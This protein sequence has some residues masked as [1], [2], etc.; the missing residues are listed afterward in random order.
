MSTL[1]EEIKA[2]LGESAMSDLDVQRQAKLALKTKKLS[3]TMQ[4]Q[5][6]QLKDI[7]HELKKV[8]AYKLADEAK[9]LMFAADRLADKVMGLAGKM[10]K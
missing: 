4:Q 5:A 3:N 9:A 1:V 6:D 7:L 2:A 8:E 10:K